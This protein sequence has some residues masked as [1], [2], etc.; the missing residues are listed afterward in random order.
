MP[1]F[2][3]VLGK[4]SLNSDLV[5]LML[6]LV[7]LIPEIM[8]NLF[9]CGD[10]LE[11]K[12]EGPGTTLRYAVLMAAKKAPQVKGASSKHGTIICKMNDSRNVVLR[13]RGVDPG[14]AGGAVAPPPPNENIGGGQTYRFAPPIILTT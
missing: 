8:M 2:D 14:G 11:S 5:Y 3:N 10:H 12:V 4:H 13:T 7:S 6:T 1:P 9:Y